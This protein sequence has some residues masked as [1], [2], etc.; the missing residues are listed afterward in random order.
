VAR[1]LQDRAVLRGRSCNGERGVG[2]AIDR[3]RV[4]ARLA[5]ASLAVNVARY[6]RRL[7]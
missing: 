3:H 7:L 5:R 2:R 6:Q 1:T 4:T